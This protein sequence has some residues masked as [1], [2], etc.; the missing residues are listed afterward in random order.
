MTDNKR[1]L[2]IDDDDDHLVLCKLI[3]QRKGYEATT[4]PEVNEIMETIA[5]FKPGLIFIDHFIQGHTGAEVVKMIKSDPV[6]KHIPVIYFSAIDDIETH[7]KK[8]GADRWLEK[9][10]KFDELLGIVKNYLP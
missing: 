10:F 6:N 9:P 2:L 8:A 3:L 1:I 5:G 7:A 4:L